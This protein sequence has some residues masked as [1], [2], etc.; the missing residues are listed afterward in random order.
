MAATMPRPRTIHTMFIDGSCRGRCWSRCESNG[1]AATG[2]CETAQCISALLIVSRDVGSITPGGS[3]ARISSSWRGRG[4]DQAKAHRRT[5]A[6]SRYR[7]HVNNF[8]PAILRMLGGRE[9][10]DRAERQVAELHA[11]QAARAEVVRVAVLRGDRSDLPAVD[12]AYDRAGHQ[13]L[14]PTGKQSPRT[15]RRR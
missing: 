8:G 15:R 10:H 11:T 2:V 13:T 4:A 7:T 9:A 1:L 5:A 14:P 3:R 12:E 6:D